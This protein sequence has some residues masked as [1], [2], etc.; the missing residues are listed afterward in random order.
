MIKILLSLLLVGFWPSVGCAH[1]LKEETT[2]RQFFKTSQE[3]YPSSFL[4]RVD[5]V[6]VLNLDER[7]EKWEMT[8]QR[9]IPY[10]IGFH[11]FSAINGEKFSKEVWDRF[12]EGQ[13]CSSKQALR[14]IKQRFI[15]GKLGCILTHLSALQ[16]SYDRGYQC[17][18]ILQ[19][20]IE[21]L[22]DPRL[23][24]GY[25]DQLNL[26]DPDWGLL[27]TDLDMRQY[28]NPSRPWKADGISKC[29]RHDQKAMP[30]AWYHERDD[31]SKDFQTIRSRWGFHS[32]VVSRRGMEQILNY[33]KHVRIHT[34]FDADIHFVPDLKKYGLKTPLISN[35]CDWRISDSSLGF[36]ELQTLPSP[37]C[38]LEK[39]LPYKGKE[40]C[41]SQE[42]INVFQKNQP[43]TVLEVGGGVGDLTCA[44]A[45]IIPLW[46]KVYVLDCWKDSY[47]Q[48]LSNMVQNRFF[49]R[50][51]PWRMDIDQAIDELKR[52]K[53]KVDLLFLHEEE[54]AFLPQL[55]PFVTK[56][57]GIICGDGEPT[58]GVD[59]FALHHGWKIQTV[60]N[61]W[62]MKRR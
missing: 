9:L 52:Q 60:D 59:R 40:H 3:V 48:F 62:I 14:E 15:K 37:Y 35:A 55:A 27:F 46:G 6:Y 24:D 44:L 17:V 53:L 34:T 33:F 51:I 45:K 11:R 7:P 13:R 1:L 32:V 54:V 43:K 41:L 18:W 50:V 36:K 30:E 25:I 47:A 38:F 28:E 12:W 42:Q 21:V 26:L 58:E 61:L 2:I 19:D 23:I 57:T 29:A 20:D 39:I 4:K 10:G 8:Y 16:D 5:S 49:D 56:K 22:G 31:I